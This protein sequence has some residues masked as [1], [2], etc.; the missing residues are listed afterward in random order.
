MNRQAEHTIQTL[1]DMLG[2]CVIDFKGNWDNHLPSI[3]FSFEVGESSLIG[4]EVIYE[5]LEKVQ[6][7]RDR[8]KTAYNRQKSYADNRRRNIDIEV[9]HM[10]YSKI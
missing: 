4:P 2:A 5:A 6:L 1:K 9:G 3:E 10:V 7:I 8:L